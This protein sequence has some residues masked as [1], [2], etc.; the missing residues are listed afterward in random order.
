M[1]YYRT[2]IT[3]FET[4]TGLKVYAGKR[5]STY[6]DSK[7]DPYTGSGKVIKAAKRKYGL[8]CIKSI[9]WFDHETKEEMNNAEIDLIIECKNKH[10]DSCTNLAKGGTGGNALEFASDEKKAEFSHKLS[11]YMTNYH[12]NLSEEEKNKLADKQRERH[13]SKTEEERKEFAS[14][15]RESWYNMPDDKK[16]E[17]NDKIRE[18]YKNCS[19]EDKE[20]MAKSISDSYKNR[21]EEQK[22][23]YIDKLRDIRVD[24]HKNRTEE[25]KANTA[26]KISISMRKSPVWHGDLYTTLWETWLDLGKPRYGTFQT[27]CRRNGITDLSLM[28]LVNHFNERYNEELQ[29]DNDSIQ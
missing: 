4:S 18:W 14:K 13:Q 2:Y 1:K 21:T 25:Q 6:K 22:A 7:D 8:D 20:S 24:W 27:H 17:R 12:K 10:G 29:S 23:E 26:D 9:E 19:I 11:S 16:A 15:C 3:T 28:G 5:E